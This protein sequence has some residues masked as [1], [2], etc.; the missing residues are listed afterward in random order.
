M[1]KIPKLP[2]LAGGTQP[3]AF[4]DERGILLRQG[5]Q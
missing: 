1:K 3:H 5:P 2:N 4:L